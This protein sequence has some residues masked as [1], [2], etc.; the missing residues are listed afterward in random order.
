M[1]PAPSHSK[2]PPARAEAAEADTDDGLEEIIVTARRRAESIQEAP[3]SITAFSGDDIDAL[4]IRDLSG[5][6]D[7]IP[8][9]VFMEGGP[10]AGGSSL[11][12]I[13][14]VGSAGTD[15]P[16]TD[17]GVGVYVDGVFLPRMQ[18]GVRDLLDLERIEVLRGPQGTLF[19]KNTIGG[20]ISLITKKPNDEFHGSGRV[21]IGNYNALEAKFKVNVP[22]TDN[23]FVAVSA[24][25]S[26]RDGFVTNLAGGPKQ[27]D[28]NR[29]S[30]RLAAR[31]LPSDR[32]E[33]NLTV[34]FTRIR[35]VGQSRRTHGIFPS[36]FLVHIMNNAYIL[37]GRQAIT[38][39]WVPGF[40]ETFSGSPNQNHGDDWGAALTVD[41]EIGDATLT[42]VTSYRE[43]KFDNKH[44]LDGMPVFFAEQT[45]NTLDQNQFS[46]EFRFAGEAFNDKLDWLIGA[47]Y[48]DDNNENAN[49]QELFGEI[50]ELLE[51]LPGAIIAPP[52]AP[53]FLCGAGIFPCWG[54]AGNPMNQN[55]W[56][57]TGPDF[58]GHGELNSESI[59]VFIHGTYHV[60]DRLGVTAGLRW[61]DEKKDEATF[62]RT[63][64]ATGA[65]L[66]C[67]PAV[68]C[69][70]RGNSWTSWT[71]KIS[72]EFQ[73]TPDHLVYAALAG[74]SRPTGSTIACG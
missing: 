3:L 36:A 52:G 66:G 43:L 16:R 59:A 40:H 46:Q 30:A 24:I 62:E 61:S 68:G 4:N 49:N 72:V 65:S 32:A 57:T 41:Y 9:V 10:G 18:G 74:A 19:G 73:A 26:D 28:K 12:Y 56:N 23:F 7:F 6:A 42:S 35:E 44:D 53:A 11:I 1:N 47:Y 17:T 67:N 14:G 48:F 22:V 31:W 25:A 34:D 20:A 15:T 33:V 69:F 2:T 5:T 37:N 38:D 45:L 64:L 21:T 51:A 55:P 63:S 39:A 58:I 13:R 54:G 70:D 8:N 27:G 50:F 60:T 29:E 71:P